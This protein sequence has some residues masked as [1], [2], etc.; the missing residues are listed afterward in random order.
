MLPACCRQGRY[1]SRQDV[2]TR[3]KAPSYAPL[4]YGLHAISDVPAPFPAFPRVPCRVCLQIKYDGMKPANHVTLRNGT[5]HLHA[6]CNVIYGVPAPFPAF[7]RVPRYVYLQIKYE[8]MKPA[9]H[10]T[11][12]HYAPTCVMQRYFQSICQTFHIREIPENH[13]LPSL[14]SLLKCFRLL[15]KINTE[16]A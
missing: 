9:N 15:N 4:P 3:Y 7:P 12:R 16:T 10:V 11:I 5:M 2:T 6:S 8:G 1:G 13:C 14:F